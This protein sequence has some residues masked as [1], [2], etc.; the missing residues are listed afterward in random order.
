MEKIVKLATKPKRAAPKAKVSRGFIRADDETSTGEPLTDP[1]V[2]RRRV[3]ISTSTPSSRER[4]HK[5]GAFKRL[6]R[7]SRFVCGMRIRPCVP[8]PRG[9]GTPVPRECCRLTQRAINKQVIFKSLLVLHTLLR[10][11]S[12]EPTYSYLSASSISLSLSSSD[13]PNL[14]AYASY[15]GARIKSYGN[16]KRDVIRDKSDKRA[17][18]RLRGLSVDKGLLREV[19]EVQRMIASLV[20]A[21]V[22]ANRPRLR[23]YD[24]TSC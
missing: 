1:P 17:V 18:N 14:A 24:M 19:R 12:L 23:T 5:T 15:L 22:S 13:T 3:A 10:S 7:R 16:L 2:L 9:R 6:S 4:L 8:L 20:E 11:G 21:K